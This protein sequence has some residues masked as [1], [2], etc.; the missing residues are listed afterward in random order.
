M[1]HRLDDWPSFQLAR[2]HYASCMDS[3]AREEA[4][5]EPMLV[6][7]ERVGGWPVLDKEEEG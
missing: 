7:L 1:G 4:G 6:A 2:D 5:V 3:G